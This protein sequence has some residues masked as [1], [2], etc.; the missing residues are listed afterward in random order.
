MTSEQTMTVETRRRLLSDNGEEGTFLLHTGSLAPR[1][2]GGGKSQP[3]SP[4]LCHV[5]PRLR[6]ESVPVMGVI[7]KIKTTPTS[8]TSLPQIKRKDLMRRA[9]ESPQARVIPQ[10]HSQRITQPHEAHSQR[11]TQPHET[12]SQRITQP[13][14]AQRIT[15]DVSLEGKQD[16]IFEN[17]IQ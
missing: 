15:H 12:F 8:K 1:D 6:S 4:R 7:S 17:L 13:Q 14:D 10:A 9:R 11:T 3:S 2:Q 5:Y 16:G